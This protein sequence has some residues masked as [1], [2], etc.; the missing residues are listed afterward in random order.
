MSHWKIT[1]QCVTALLKSFLKG[2]SQIK[3][4]TIHNNKKIQAFL[5]VKI[6]QFYITITK[7]IIFAH[8]FVKAVLDYTLIK[9]FFLLG[10]KNFV[11]S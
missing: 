11:V 2:Q 10:A 8:P 4:Y 7:P 1:F 6:Y 9:L 3:K 5:Q